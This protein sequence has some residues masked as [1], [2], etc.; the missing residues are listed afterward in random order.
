MR[1]LIREN[2]NDLTALMIIATFFIIGFID[3][4][5]LKRIEAKVD[6]LIVDY[7]KAIDEFVA[8]TIKEDVENG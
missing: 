4:Y 6:S 7:R 3:V 5:I 1:K 8:K 2:M